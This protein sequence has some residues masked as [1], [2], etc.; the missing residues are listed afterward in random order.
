MLGAKPEF[1]TRTQLATSK[2]YAMATS[3]P[4]SDEP[5]YL[6]SADSHVLE[7]TDLWISRLP[8]HLVDRA[9]VL[10]NRREDKPGATDPRDRLRVMQEDAVSME[11]LFPTYALLQYG[12][13]DPEL[14]EAC[15]RVYNEWIAGYCA[16][17]PGRLVGIPCISTYDIGHAIKELERCKQLGLAGAQTWHI[18]PKGID[19]TTNHYE[20]L[21]AAAAEMDMPI[22]LHILTGFSY[23]KHARP[24][25]VEH[26]RGSVELKLNDAIRILF[27]F[28]FYGV[29]DRHPKMKLV[30]VEF[31]IGWLPWLLQQWDYYANRF[32]DVNPVPIQYK[33]SE[34]FNRQIFASFINDNVGTAM[35]GTGWGRDNCMWSNDFPHGNT[36]WPDSRK[37]IARDLS[38][39]D[40]EV[41]EKLLHK[42]VAD[43]YQL[44]LAPPIQLS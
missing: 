25:G 10:P 37:V 41:R 26:Y 20:R 32:H 27:D 12:I 18:P 21:W 1:S 36:S 35:I 6:I 28:I 3:D 42:T 5:E 17:T 13:E 29:L 4:V 38:H 44:E 40:P 24:K 2:G 11:V 22:N 14:Q 33:P 34:Y 16:G 30:L 7:P 15:F 9:P 8:K 23:T 19:Y 31:E 39:L 43:L